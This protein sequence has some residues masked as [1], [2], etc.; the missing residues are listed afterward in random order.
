MLRK[1]LNHVK[2]RKLRE[3]I[4]QRAPEFHGWDHGLRA[5]AD[6]RHVQAWYDSV[7]SRRTAFLERATPLPEPLPEAG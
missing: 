4:A 2:C 5:Q 6:K 7:L 3:A 1:S